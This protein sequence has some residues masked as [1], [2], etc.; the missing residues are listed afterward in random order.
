[1]S[2]TIIKVEAKSLDDIT[3][4]EHRQASLPMVGQGPAVTRGGGGV[5][6]RQETLSQRGAT[7]ALYQGP[8]AT[9]SVIV[10][11]GYTRP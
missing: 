6:R 3:K 9:C 2:Q 10:E 8:E 11:T 5:G 7:R 1:V 4:G